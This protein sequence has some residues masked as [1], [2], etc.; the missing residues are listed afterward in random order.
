VGGAP[1]GTGIYLDD[2]VGNSPGLNLVGGSNDDTAIIY[3]RDDAVAGDSDLTIQLCD[4]A[5]DSYLAV[6]NSADTLVW[7]VNSNG[8]CSV[9]DLFNVSGTSTFQGPVT[10]YDGVGDSPL[11]GLVG[12]SN[13]DAIYVNLVDNALAGQSDVRILLCDAAGNSRLY[14]TDSAY[15]ERWNVNS[16]GTMWLF[17]DFF[18][19]ETANAKQDIGITINQGEN[20]DEAFTIKSSD[21]AHGMTGQTETDTYFYISKGEASSGGAILYGLKDADGLAGYALSMQGALGEAANAGKTTGSYGVVDIQAKVKSGAS[22]TSVGADGN[23]LSIRNAATTRFI[24]DAEGS[25][26]AD[27]EWVAFDEHDDLALLDTLEQT[28]VAQGFGGWIEENKTLLERLNIAHFDDVPGHAMVNWTRLSMLMVGALRQIAP[29]L[30]R[31]EAALL[32]A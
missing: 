18:I 3:L 7:W 24:F 14:L 6:R 12:G 8:G 20:D 11:L 28:V 32:E 1:T 19:N 31:L 4:A 21:V 25:A 26:H 30:G 17:K 15:A 13:N 16:D 27:V 23:L 22:V 10:I 29:R 5:G 2:G 9:G